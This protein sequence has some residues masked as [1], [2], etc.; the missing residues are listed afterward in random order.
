MDIH[1]D[2]Q[3]KFSQDIKDKEKEL[4]GNIRNEKKCLQS[5]KKQWSDGIKKTSPIASNNA[6]NEN[7]GPSIRFPICVVPLSELMKAKITFLAETAYPR[8][9][10][11][12][13]VQT[14]T[15]NKPKSVN[16]Y[17]QNYYDQTHSLPLTSHTPANQTTLNTPTLYRNR[18]QAP[19]QIHTSSDTISVDSSAQ[20]YHDQTT[21][22]PSASYTPVHQTPSRPAHYY[23][24]EQAPVQ[25]VTFSD[26]KAVDN[27]AQNYHD[28]STPSP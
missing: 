25:S 19:A 2:S 15:F 18:N 6:T 22:L 14:H 1:D 26:P 9:C 8:N 16:N 13:P 21:F 28:Q 7:S 27:S 24:F 10:D 11:Q 5:N 12:A 23:N 4:K 3:K 20:N 17:A